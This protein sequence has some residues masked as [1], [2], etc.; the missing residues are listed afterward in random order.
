M[1]S[2][3]G[4]GRAADPIDAARA[5][6]RRR[7]L[8]GQ[9][10]YYMVTGAWP[11]IHFPSFA[12]FINLPV[13]PFQADAFAA[14]VVVVGG[15]LLEAARREAVGALATLLGLAVAAA[16]AL[17]EAVWLPRFGVLTPLWIDLGLQVA[18]ALSLGIFYP[19]EME[20]TRV[21]RRR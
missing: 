1:P 19:R 17:V 18:F 4:R 9:G 13:N 16:I 14:L 12:H 8:A 11:L 3:S 10:A 20:A 6:W 21:N 5:R 2:A 7:I 15:T